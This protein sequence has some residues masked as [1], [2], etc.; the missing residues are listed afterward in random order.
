M[1]VTLQDIETA[2]Q[3]IADSINVTICDYSR[4]AS[5]LVGSEVYFK[6]ENTQ[7]TGSFKIRGAT[8][9]ILS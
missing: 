1:K 2:R 8:N 6:L 3:A 5:S 4:S 9:K 7:R